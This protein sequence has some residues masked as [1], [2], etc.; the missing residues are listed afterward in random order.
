MNAEKVERE[1][2]KVRR[3]GDVV[4]ERHLRVRGFDNSESLDRH[5]DERAAAHAAWARQVVWVGSADPVAAINRRRRRLEA[6]WSALIEAV[7]EV[8]SGR[9][10]YAANF[11]QYEE[12][13]FWGPLDLV[14]VNAYFP[15]R[16]L[17]QPG[18]D[19]EELY[20]VFEARWGAIL[21]SILDL[22]RERGWGEKPILFTELGY[23]YRRNSTIEPWA[24][25]GFSVLPSATGE[26]LVVWEEEPVDLKERALAVR[27]LYRANRAVGEPLAGILYW[28]LSTQPYHFDDEPFV[29]IIHPEARDPLLEELQRFRRWSPLEE[30]ERRLDRLTD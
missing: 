18:G 24:A 2:D 9:V 26:K 23:V 12:V 27:A 5:L 6:H 17:W 19:P 3:H 1:H 28:K 4:E 29:L 30:I 15:L 21:R 20:S 7:R 14:S 10:T 8:Y 16:K 22:G 25:T 11:D 13:G